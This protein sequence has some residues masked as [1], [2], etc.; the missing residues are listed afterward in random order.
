MVLFCLFPQ[1]ITQ[2]LFLQHRMSLQG[3][4]PFHSCYQPVNITITAEHS[5]KAFLKWAEV[6]VLQPRINYLNLNTI[7]TFLQ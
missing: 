3:F 6:V 7:F 1:T 2:A 5:K 4:Q